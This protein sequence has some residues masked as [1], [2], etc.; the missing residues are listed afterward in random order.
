MHGT[1][2][3]LKVMDQTGHSKITW[4][5][6]NEEEVAIARTMFDEMI[7]KGKSAFRVGSD[8]GKGERI[9]SFDP[10]AEAIIIVSQLVGG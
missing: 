9:T 10:R 2:G 3:T 8:G 5:R 6:D 1:F 4:R 7:S